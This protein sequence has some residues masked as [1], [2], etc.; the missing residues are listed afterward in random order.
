MSNLAKSLVRL[1]L[2]TKGSRLP[3]T[4][5]LET[6]PTWLDEGGWAEP[7]QDVCRTFGRGSHNPWSLSP[8][9]LLIHPLHD[10]GE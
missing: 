10:L 3:F 5:A 8:K 6:P 4:D 2:V 7:D 9:A 1:A